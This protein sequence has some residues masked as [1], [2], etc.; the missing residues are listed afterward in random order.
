METKSKRNETKYMTCVD[1]AS[2]MQLT[3]R[4]VQQM[5]KREEIPGAI[6]YRWMC[7]H[8]FVKQQM[9]IA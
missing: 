8:R 7:V 6:K 9:G 1:A 3:V 2:V 4:R 5:C